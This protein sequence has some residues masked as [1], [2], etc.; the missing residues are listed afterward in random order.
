[1]KLLA[2]QRDLQ[3]KI[4]DIDKCLDIVATLQAKKGSGEVKCTRTIKFY[5]VPCST[6]VKPWKNVLYC[7][8]KS[9]KC[10]KATR[11]TELEQKERIKSSCFFEWVQT[12]LYTEAW[13][14][15]GEYS[16]AHYPLNSNHAPISP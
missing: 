4:P 1:M 14:L 6:K 12:L 15:S 9:E 13:Y 3:A 10:N 7:V 8:L 16:E 2:Q 5:T 11:L